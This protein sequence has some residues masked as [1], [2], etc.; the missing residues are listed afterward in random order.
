MLHAPHPLCPPPPRVQ[1]VLFQP[2][3][4]SPTTTK[5]MPPDIEE[6]YYNKPGYTL[7]NV[8]PNHIFLAQKAYAA[9]HGDDATAFLPNRLCAVYRHGAGSA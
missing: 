4:W 6:R 7:I 9:E 5:G 1:G 8:A 3:P 2:V